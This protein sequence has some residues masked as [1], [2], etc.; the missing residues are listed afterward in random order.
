MVGL[1]VELKPA[2]SGSVGI[3]SWIR[4]G[5]RGSGGQSLEK[6]QFRR[7][8]S[9][10]K[11][12]E[13]SNS[14]HPD[15]ETPRYNKSGV[16]AQS[17]TNKPTAAKTRFH[18]GAL[19]SAFFILATPPVVTGSSR[20]VRKQALGKGH[21]SPGSASITQHTRARSEQRSSMQPCIHL[22]ALRSPVR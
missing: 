7:F 19:T 6:T 10:K 13:R 16:M 11:G 5:A 4:H 1:N 12:L 9:D 3:Q 17:N 2:V 22:T 20:T 21:V 8:E 18:D 14:V 15:L